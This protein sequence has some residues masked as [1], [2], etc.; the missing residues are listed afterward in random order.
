MPLNVI[1]GLLFYTDIAIDE[2]DPC[3]IMCVHVNFCFIEEYI[4]ATQECESCTNLFW[5]I[6]DTIAV[7]IS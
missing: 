5:Y 1:D 6:M 7:I 4:T 3:H 2:N